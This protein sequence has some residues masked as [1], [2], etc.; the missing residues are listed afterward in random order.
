[1][2]LKA[3]FDYSKRAFLVNMIRKEELIKLIDLTS[4]NTA[5]GYQSIAKFIAKANDGF[6]GSYPASVCVYPKFAEQLKKTIKAPI[7]TCVVSTYFPSSQAP[8]EL[9]LL[10]IDYLNALKIDEIDIVLPFGDF[11]EGDYERTIN[12]LTSIRNRTKK[13]LKLIIETGLLNDQN[14]VEKA[15][16]IGIETGMD[17]IKTAT[18]KEKR[19]ADLESVKTMALTIK[20]SRKTVGLKIAGGIR[21]LEEA[22]DYIEVCR[23]ILGSGFINPASFRIGASSLYDHL[24]LNNK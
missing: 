23:N 8:L 6:N 14:L 20:K 15:T 13:V 5:D 10:E 9:K 16:H 17:F 19:G 3:F 1:M 22:N 18:G 4:L 7:K 11:I 12:E 2:I 24:I 21:T